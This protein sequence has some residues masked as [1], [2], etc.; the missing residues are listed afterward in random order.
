MPVLINIDSKS[1]N[2]EHHSIVLIQDYG[3][4]FDI[5]IS[6]NLNLENHSTSIHI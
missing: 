6:S 2:I 4:V 1:T 3:I 5:G